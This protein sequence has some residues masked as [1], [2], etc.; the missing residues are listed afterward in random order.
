MQKVA[1]TEL[2][3]AILAAILVTAIYPWLGQGAL[4]GFGVLG[5]AGVTVLF[6][7]RRGNTVVTDERDRQIDE[8]ARL[9]AIST[10]WMMLFLCLLV[11]IGWANSSNGHVVPTAMLTW[12][13][14]IHFTICLAV[15]GIAAL[16]IYRKQEHA[17]QN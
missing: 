8:R 5:F 6:L 17:A 10:A 7:R 2:I 16:L 13:V 11:I 1:W 9:R 14:W 12:L 15:K 4:G 3:V